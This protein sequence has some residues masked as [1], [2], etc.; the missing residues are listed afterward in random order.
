MLSTRGQGIISNTVH[1]CWIVQV[2]WIGKRSSR[3]TIESQ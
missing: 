2:P 3:R 1:P